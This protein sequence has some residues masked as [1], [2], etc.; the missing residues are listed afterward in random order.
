MAEPRLS[1]PP[2]PIFIAGLDIGQMHDPTALAIAEREMVLYA[3]KL[4]PRFLVRYLERVPLGTPYPEMVKG[5]R[6]TLHTL[7]QAYTLVIDATGVGRPIVDLFRAVSADGLRTVGVQP[8]A[9][10][11]PIAVTLTS[12]ATPH[13]ERWDEWSVP[14]RDLVL[15]MQVA[16]QHGRLRVARALPEAATL[17][18]ELQNFQW[19]VSQIGQDQYGA[20]RE[21]TYDDLVLA[22]ALSVWWGTL[23][24]PTSLPATQQQYATPTGNP[25]RR[26]GQGDQ[27]AQGAG[28]LWRR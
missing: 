11:R 10:S 25:L 24:A 28:S 2:P 21:G 26:P 4:E 15:G 18:R 5:V 8:P 22:V 12:G 7:E 14:K 9:S 6:A 23:Y 1:M 27:V 19:K 3:G 20:W 16:S 13:S 17:V